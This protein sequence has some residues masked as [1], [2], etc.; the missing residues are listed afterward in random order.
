MV[1]RTMRAAR[2]CTVKPLGVQIMLK[3]ETSFFK[4]GKEK[5]RHALPIERKTQYLGRRRCNE[6]VIRLS[7]TLLIVIIIETKV[8]FI[9]MKICCKIQLDMFSCIFSVG[10]IQLKCKCHCTDPMRCG[11]TRPDPFQ[12]RT[13]QKQQFLSF[14]FFFSSTSLFFIWI[15]IFSQRRLVSSIILIPPHSSICLM[16]VWPLFHCVVYPLLLLLLLFFYHSH[17]SSILPLIFIVLGKM[18]T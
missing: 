8:K 4:G 14:L 13:E 2:L 1:K 10:Q 17:P 7:L 6:I 12:F 11:S 9:K 16:R 15:N 18:T 5:V 3:N